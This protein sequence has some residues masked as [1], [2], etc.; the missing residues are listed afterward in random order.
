MLYY[1]N[2][3]KFFT[4]NLLEGSLKNTSDMATS[5]LFQSNVKYKSFCICACQ[6]VWSD[7]WAANKTL[8]NN[9]H[10]Y[11]LNNF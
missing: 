8:V 5:G 6:L 11:K 3:I 2:S 7:R 10:Y 1:I 4:L 9:N